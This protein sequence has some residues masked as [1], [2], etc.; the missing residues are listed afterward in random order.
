[1]QKWEYLQISTGSI[2]DKKGNREIWKV[3]G[4]AIGQRTGVW[5]IDNHPIVGYL[6]QLGEL[7]WELV[8]IDR[9][10]S[11]VDEAMFFKRPK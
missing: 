9:V 10:G 11:S 8:S 3:N 2:P 5:E 7:G 4:T 6:N 1:M